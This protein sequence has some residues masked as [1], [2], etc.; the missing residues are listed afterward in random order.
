V[1][2][3]V[4]GQSATEFVVLIG[5][6]LLFF[7]GMLALSF[8]RTKAINEEKQDRIAVDILTKMQKEI[9]LASS[10]SDGYSREF[11]LPE[12]IGNNNYVIDLQN[13]TIVL[14]VSGEVYSRKV[15]GVTGMLG[16]EGI[17]KREG[18]IVYV[19]N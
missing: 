1:I 17:V 13:N 8:D 5:V 16:K 19:E 14:T 6:L 18:G 11:K 15:P 9:Q 4:K 2:S 12:K 7:L 3:S 10:V